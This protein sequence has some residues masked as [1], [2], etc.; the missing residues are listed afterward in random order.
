MVNYFASNGCTTANLKSR[1]IS[2]Y[3]STEF[4]NL[5]YSNAEKLLAL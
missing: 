5:G 1:G 3:I 2:V 4:S